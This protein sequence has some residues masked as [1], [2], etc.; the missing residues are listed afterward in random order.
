MNWKLPPDISYK[1]DE[2]H[3]TIERQGRIAWRVD[4]WV[5]PISSTYWWTLTR[6]GARLSARRILRRERRNRA[7]AGAREEIR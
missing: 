2:I 5:S 1:A 4:V 6:W 7:R 3:A